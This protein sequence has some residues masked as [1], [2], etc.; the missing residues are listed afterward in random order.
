MNTLHG[1][2]TA[3]T[4]LVIAFLFILV[5]ILQYAFMK[6]FLYNNKA[7]ALQAQIR[8]WPPE[9]FFLHHEETQNLR[10]PG[11]NRPE[12]AIMFQPGMIV[13]YIDNSGKQTLLSDTDTELTPIISEEQYKQIF[14][15]ARNHIGVPYYIFSD[16]DGNEY[17]VVFREQA[18]RTASRGMLQV[19]I[20]LQSLQN[21]LM[22][23]QFIYVTVAL[24]ALIAGSILMLFSLRKTLRPLHSMIQAVE[25]TNAEN[26]TEQLPA[27]Q[28][29]ELKQLAE[30]YNNMLSRLESSFE[31]E[32]LTNER[33]RQFIA[34]ASH[35][36][37]TP[38]T[39]I[40]G[41]I[42][43]L[44][45]GAMNQP[46]QLERS[47]KA[48]EQ[49]SKRMKSLV[50]GLLELVKQDHVSPQHENFT[51]IELSSILESMLLQLQ[52][53]SGERSLQI[54]YEKA[55]SYCIMGSKHG[56][57][58]TILNL[59]HNAIQH[60]HVEAGCI[61]LRLQKDEHHVILSITDNG[62]G[63]AKE[64]HQHI[65]E[66]FYRIDKA[67]TRSQGGAGLGLSITKSIIDAHHGQIEIESELGAGTTFTILF[68][69][70]R[71]E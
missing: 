46:M 35:E 36:L 32:R 63:I 12:P 66:R 59:V 21:Q 57:K 71:S 8:S 69:L 3:I 30:A 44:Q 23:Q 24:V 16:Q 52:I 51:E 29:Q 64:H 37:R 68:P 60:T 17:M 62:E 10:P 40:H 53:M 33:M 67:R 19:S 47:L 70:P 5:G 14:E 65:F 18:G 45:R 38:I 9:P 15:N 22:T 58:Q 42:E 7:E 43:V 11:S 31:S 2:I 25:R 20:E 4:L 49:E 13:S 1:R 54:Y 39:S 34:D 28:Q 26:L 27:M 56:I 48:M 41:F 50:E 6:D 55:I 61:S